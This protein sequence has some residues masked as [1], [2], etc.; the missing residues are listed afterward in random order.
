MTIGL[1]DPRNS[2]YYGR[3]SFASPGGRMDS[4][5]LSSA[6]DQL[7]QFMQQSNPNM[8]VVRN[9]QRTRVDGAQALVLE[10]VNDSP[11]GGMETDRLVTVFQRNGLL[12][13]FIGVAP[14][15]EFGRYQNA[16]E[17]IVSS[18]RLLD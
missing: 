17:Q 1:F 2:G 14:E 13:Y 15:N 11:A 18:V 10:L 4:S 12:R 9:S 5:S 3:N 8:R 7:V 16:F 6:T